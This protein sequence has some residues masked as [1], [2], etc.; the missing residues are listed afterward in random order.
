MLGDGNNAIAVKERINTIDAQASG[1]QQQK[2]NGVDTDVNDISDRSDAESGSDEGKI[3]QL[4]AMRS[5]TPGA[6][7]LGSAIASASTLT[8]PPDAFDSGA[9]FTR[10]KVGKEQVAYSSVAAATPGPDTAPEPHRNRASRAGCCKPSLVRNFEGW[11]AAV[12]KAHSA[13][14]NLLAQ[15]PMFLPLWGSDMFFK[16]RHREVFKW[17]AGS[18]RLVGRVDA[19]D[20]R[21]LKCNNAAYGMSTVMPPRGKWPLKYF[22]C[23]Q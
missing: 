21:M 15:T 5:P 18:L 20:V 2:K 12:T 14:N 4:K 17:H 7:P 9:I 8:P 10:K 3:A 22:R 13:H 16:F 19:T 11:A 23:K 6:F 1:D